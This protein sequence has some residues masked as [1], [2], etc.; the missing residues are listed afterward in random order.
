[1]TLPKIVSTEPLFSGPA[2][3]IHRETVEFDENRRFERDILKHPGAVVIV[4][5]IADQRFIMLRQY[6][7][8]LREFILEF[9]AGTLEPN[10]DPLVCAKRELIEETGYAA[11]E[12]KD[13]GTLYPAPG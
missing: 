11:S 6:R 2:F 13:L 1:M 4:P 10:E 12:W 9:P 3:D 8:A 7:H 5:M